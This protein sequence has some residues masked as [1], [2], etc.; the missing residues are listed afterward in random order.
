L[1][2]VQA[3]HTSL[4]FLGLDSFP[5]GDTCYVAIRRVLNVI[6][7]IKILPLYNPINYQSIVP[8]RVTL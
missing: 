3:S 7:K 4:V 5:D 2:R 8:I 6:A 1:A